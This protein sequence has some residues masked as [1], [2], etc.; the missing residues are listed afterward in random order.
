MED[1]ETL[2]FEFCV[3][4]N[5]CCRSST[6]RR[7]TRAV[8]TFVMDAGYVRTYGFFETSTCGSSP[9][10]E[11]RRAASAVRPSAPTVCFAS[12]SARPFEKP[13]ACFPETSLTL[14]AFIRV[15]PMR[16]S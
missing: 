14:T 2:I 12:G 11:T 5:S 7:H 10:F 4:V 3:T 1:P 6:F 9:S 16:M 13:S 8:I 15:S